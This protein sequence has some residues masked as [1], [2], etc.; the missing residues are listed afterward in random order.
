MRFASS[1][2]SSFPIAAG[3]LLALAGVA[4]TANA[5]DLNGQAVRVSQNYPTMSAIFTNG[6][7]Q[8]VTSSG[9]TYFAQDVNIQVKPSQVVFTFT[10]ST[11]FVNSDFNGY[12][13]AEVGVSPVTFTSVTL[14]AAST[15]AGFDS[16]RITFDANN[17]FANFRGLTY[18]VGQNVT[19]NLGFAPAVSA[20]PEPGEWAT[21]GMAGAGLCGL[22]VRARR[23]KAASSP[24]TA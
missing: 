12:Q 4:N 18:T 2:R 24:A 22:M 21:M 13:I 7:T 14:D 11:S 15:V 10:G 3:A 8:T 1:L 5:Q 19:L 16:S 9:A 20:V 17:I 6:G 23:K